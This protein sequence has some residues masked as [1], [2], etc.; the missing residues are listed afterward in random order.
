MPGCILLL[1]Q[2]TQRVQTAST[3]AD[4]QHTNKHVQRAASPHPKL[5]NNQTHQA[6]SILQDCSVTLQPSAPSPPLVVRYSVGSSARMQAP[7]FCNINWIRWHQQHPPAKGPCSSSSSSCSCLAVISLNIRVTSTLIRSSHCG[8]QLVVMV[9]LGS[10]RCC[11][12]TGTGHRQ[13]SSTL[14]QLV[15]AGAARQDALGHV[16][17][18]VLGGILHV[19]LQ[20]A[21]E[22]RTGGQVGQAVKIG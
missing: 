18:N 12:T 7:A 1:Q 22:D 14:G 9:L 4:C 17:A 21:V 10:C 3:A 15:Q 5:T 2:P 19:G 6:K 16:S 11:C 20:E 8:V 13:G